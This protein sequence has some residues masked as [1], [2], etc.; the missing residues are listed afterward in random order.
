MASVRVGADESNEAAKCRLIGNAIPP[1][2]APA[3]Q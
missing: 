2:F 3:G 1:R